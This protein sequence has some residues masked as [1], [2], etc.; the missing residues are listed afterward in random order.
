M[1]R[2]RP[3]IMTT[4]SMFAFSTIVASAANAGWMVKG[5]GFT[6]GTKALAS[7]AAVDQLINLHSK[8]LE[9]LCHGST[10]ND[11]NGAINGT[12]EMA[13]ITSLEFTECEDGSGICALAEN[14]FKSLPLLA[15]LALDGSNP[16]AVQ[17]LLLPKTKNLFATVR[18]EGAQCAMAGV[19]PVVGSESFLAPTG[20]LERT[21]QSITLLGLPTLVVEGLEGVLSGTILT[22]LASGEPFSFL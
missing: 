11:R 19:L 9:I 8:D 10:M 2:I 14:Q 20:R 7:T 13:D 17:G 6:S 18:F 1:P 15:D 16:S 21:L 5:T 4:A 3:L 22:G 12:T